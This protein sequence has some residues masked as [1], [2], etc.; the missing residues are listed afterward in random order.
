LTSSTDAWRLR[1]IGIVVYGVEPFQLSEDEDRSHGDDER[2]SLDNVRFGLEVT[3]SVVL[4]VAG[5][6]AGR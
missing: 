2:L 4:D 1:Q 5:T 6:P 3:Y